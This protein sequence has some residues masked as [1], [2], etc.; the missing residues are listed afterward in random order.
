MFINS[1]DSDVAT[2]TIAQ[3]TIDIT[4]TKEDNGFGFVLRGGHNQDNMKTRALV[5]THIRPGSAADK[6]VMQ[7]Y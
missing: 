2:P 1:T 7:F 6:Y 5:V 3:K 4:L